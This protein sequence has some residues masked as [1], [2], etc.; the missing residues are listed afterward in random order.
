M[1]GRFWGQ[2]KGKDVELVTE[3]WAQTPREVVRAAQ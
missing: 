3:S 1:K 2:R